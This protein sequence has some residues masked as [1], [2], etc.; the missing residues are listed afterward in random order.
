MMANVASIKEPHCS[1]LAP[2]SLQHG[3]GAASGRALLSELEQPLTASE[4]EHLASPKTLPAAE[5]PG[6]LGPDI[7]R[8]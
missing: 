7:C 2:A 8:A 6:E 1:H 3:R 5:L 4:A